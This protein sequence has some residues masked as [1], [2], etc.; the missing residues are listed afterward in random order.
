MLMI[1]LITIHDIM[2]SALP[3]NKMY[4]KLYT[5]SSDTFKGHPFF[6]RIERVVRP[7]PV[8]A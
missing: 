7:H 6:N 4:F 2:H 8:H 1:F 5:N 3:N